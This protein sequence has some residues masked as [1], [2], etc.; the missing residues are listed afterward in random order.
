MDILQSFLRLHVPQGCK[1]ELFQ[2]WEE[3]IVTPHQ[4]GAH[5]DVVARFARTVAR[6]AAGD[7][8]VSTHKGLITPTG[9]FIPDATVAPVGRFRGQEPWSP[10]TGVALVLEITSTN[11]LKEREPKRLGYAAAGIPCY[12][13][14]DRDEG[15]V[16]LFTEPENGDYT[17]LVETGFGR[18]I[19]LPAPFSFALDTAP[20]R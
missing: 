5:E 13:L 12:L 11:P 8:Y 15:R 7:L 2:A 20:L 6:E 10:P 4:G 18:T 19:D 9:R 16:T 17:A 3:I 14:A 1:I